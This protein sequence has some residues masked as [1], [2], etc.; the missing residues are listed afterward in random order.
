MP[1]VQETLE[2]K[3]QLLDYSKAEEKRR[4]DEAKMRVKEKTEDLSKQFKSLRE[5]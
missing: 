4:K 1:Q 3:K 2:A 5:N